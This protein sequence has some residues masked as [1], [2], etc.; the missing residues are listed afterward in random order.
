MLTIYAKMLT[1]F[2]M[3]KIV[4]FYKYENRN[5]SKY[6]FLESSDIKIVYINPVLTRRCF[7][8]RTTSL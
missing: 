6:N 1:E 4:V 8:I 5:I 7:D 2:L 3:Q